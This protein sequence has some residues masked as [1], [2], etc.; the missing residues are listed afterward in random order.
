MSESS[1]PVPPP[2]PAP[3][4]AEAPWNQLLTACDRLSDAAKALQ[5]AGGPKRLL[6]K[7]RPSSIERATARAESAWSQLD[8]VLDVLLDRRDRIS[9][10]RRD[11]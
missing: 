6:S 3:D 11:G 9:R 7:M 4:P 8:D 1:A 10:H 2:P 5:E